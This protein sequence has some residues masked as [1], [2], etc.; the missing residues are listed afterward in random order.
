ML[1]RADKNIVKT[2][3]SSANFPVPSASN[4]NV[5][6]VDDEENTVYRWGLTEDGSTRE[7]V[8]ISG[9]GSGPSSDVKLETGIYLKG[10]KTTVSVAKGNSLTI[11]YVFSSAN[12]MTRYNKKTQQFEKI[13]QQTGT[14]GS[15]RYLLDGIQFD[16]G[17]IKQSNYN[18][19]DD[20]KNTYNKF[21]V[22]ASRFTASTHELKIIASDSAG[23]SATETVTIN[24]ISASIT[25][26]YVV[27]PTNL[28][29]NINIP[30]T[31][32][33]T[34]D[35]E[36]FYS[37]DNEETVKVQDVPVGS[38]VITISLSPEGREHGY[39]TIKIWATVY[40]E[41]SDTTI[42]TKVLS[43]DVIWYDPSNSTPIVTTSFSLSEGEDGKYEITQ[44][45]YATLTYQVYPASTVD[46]I[47]HDLGSGNQRIVNT[48]NVDTIAKSWAYTFDTVGEYELFINVH[49]DESSSLSS[50]KYLVNVKKSEISMD[51][52]PGSVL[53][54]TAK[55]RSN[56]EANPAQWHSEIGD[57]DA[58]LEGF[59]WNGNSGWHTEGATT[60]LRVAAGAKCTIPYQPFGGVDKIETGQVFE[61]DFSTSNLSDSTAEV[62]KCSSETDKSG[63]VITATGAYFSSTDFNQSTDG[64]ARI[65]VPVKENERIRLSFVI[66][67]WLADE[68]GHSK[69]D[70]AA[71]VNLWNGS[72][73]VPMNS[74]ELGWW[75]F[76]KIYVNGVCVGIYNYEHGFHQ[77]NPSSIV[78]G[79]DVATIDVYSIRCYDTVLYDRAIVNNFIADTQDPVEKLRLFKR[80]N[81]LN[82]AGTDVEPSA[83]RRLM[84]CLFVT[85]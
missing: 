13:Q 2:Y 31:V 20:T 67:P 75:R 57:V 58:E 73:Y 48:L 8:E 49:Y 19:T 64:D 72:A 52:T 74:V 53:Y 35:A 28:Q 69:D 54:F 36:L 70:P 24:V 7:Y 44:Y 68:Q 85:C 55:N 32:T 77:N 5:F 26:S 78:I 29:T 10:G 22:P 14:V 71:I 25:S 21:V 50:E 11:E 76:V 23:N 6:Y 4:K 1:V 33:S 39:H 9:S 65:F 40:I 82:E 59:L 27:V 61:I 51:A 15:V 12:T 46:L 30:V 60:S 66:T 63:I 41:E 38:P 83:L 45:D 42:S 34:S 37:I 17:N 79:S 43:Y 56:D 84:P 3:D 80:N 47:I 18:E 62:V 16:S 81:I